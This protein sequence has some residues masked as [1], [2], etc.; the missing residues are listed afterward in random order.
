M[1]A[2]HLYPGLC[3]HWDHH[4]DPVETPQYGAGVD[5]EQIRRYLRE[6][7]PDVTQCHTM[8]CYGYVS[9]PS[10]IAP[11]VPGLVGDPLATWSQVCA[12]EGVAFGCYVAA[13]M[14]QYPGPA[15]EWRLVNRSGDTQ[16]EGFC[17]NGPWTEEYF[18]PVLLEIM[19]RYHPV[20]FWLDG[21]WLP[22]REN[23]CYCE[24]CQRRFQEQCGR[25][26]PQ[27]P[28][29]ADWADLIGFH[30]RSL[31][32][33]V[34]RIGRAI[35]ARDPRILLACNSLYYYKDLRMPIPEVDWLSWDVINTPD[36]AATSFEAT[37][38]ATAGKPADLM[39]YEQG[40]LHWTPRI[41]RRPRP[42]A[43]IKT[44][45]STLLAHG[46]RLNLWHDPEPDGAILDDK[47]IIA[48]QIAAF[49]RERQEWTIGN[50]SVAQVALL[51][52][53]RQHLADPLQSFSRRDVQRQNTVVRAAH[54]LLQQAHIPCDVVRDDTLL[55]RLGQ[56]R[57][58]ILPEVTALGPAVAEKLRI[59]ADAGGSLVLVPAEPL[60]GEADWL[61]ALLGPAAS[62]QPAAG[63]SGAV[64]YRGLAVALEGRRYRLGGPW[65]TLLS[66][67][68]S[69]EPWLAELAV[70]AGRVLAVTH[71]ALSD[72]AEAHWPAL[73]N[74]F[75][76]VV[77]AAL[78]PRPLVELAG[79]PSIELVA[80]RRGADLYVHLVNLSPGVSF[81]QAPDLFFDEVPVHRDLV[82]TVRPPRQ[83]KAVV[84]LPGEVLLAVTAED[85]ALHIAVPELQHH[86][87]ICLSGALGNGAC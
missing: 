19:E 56:Y 84:A 75:A 3:I 4:P 16:K 8:G 72:Y 79:H 46:V 87:T 30:E 35:K 25:P 9:Y 39:I 36:L 42:L 53:R 68:G 13:H 38:L 69:D 47:R 6:V 80:N 11:P 67:R 10:R 21:V 83:P 31:D 71:E 40:V 76:D 78:G 37:Y 81:G 34:G 26:M 73:R 7:R 14:G 24:H 18:I 44:E 63:T 48:R 70:G 74:L 45:T 82:V 51:A 20:H 61:G 86:L 1:S 32:A 55:T 29:P 28:G 57:V 49:V 5:A 2:S 58:V 33:S 27:E 60:P 23:L 52:S 59:H 77:R 50:D 62:L 85:G 66:Y 65:Q 15:A 64:V 41:V 54:E 43:Q 12:E 17:A 22:S